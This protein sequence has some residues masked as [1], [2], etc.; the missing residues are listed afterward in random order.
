MAQR[1]CYGFDTGPDGEL[2]I[3]P[4]E[5]TIVYWIFDRYLNGDR[6]GKVAAG[7]EE[8]GIAYPTGKSKWN[9]EAINK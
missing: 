2:V 4:D 3:K 7:P 1:R 6:L 9:R 8:Q 5:T